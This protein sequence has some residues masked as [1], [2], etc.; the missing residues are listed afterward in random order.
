MGKHKFLKAVTTVAAV[1]GVCYLFKDKIKESNIYQ[2]MDV[3]DK[4]EKVKTTI[5][6][7]MPV[8][9]DTG[10]DKDY[11]SLDDE[12]TTATDDAVT[13]DDTVTTDYTE[14]APVS[15][16]I[17]E[18]ESTAETEEKT[19]SEE[20]V[21]SSSDLTSMVS[22]LL[23]DIPVIKPEDDSPLLYENEGL[24]DSSLED[25]FDVLNEQDKLDF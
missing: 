15:E 10:T 22:D 9:N 5:K 3:E 21:S 20:A 13:A 8:K 19:T 18:D 25:D 16:N 23:S 24:S 14:D 7:K 2:S 12:D 17:P 4:V 1:G 11:F 6:E